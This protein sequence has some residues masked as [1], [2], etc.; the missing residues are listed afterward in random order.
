METPL[1]QNLRPLCALILCLFF[2]LAG[3]SK[4]IEAPSQLFTGNNYK[5]GQQAFVNVQ[6]FSAD[7]KVGFSDGQRG[8]NANMRW[9]QDGQEYQF[10]LYGPL[11]SGAVQIMGG[12]NHVSLTR[13]DGHIIKSKSPEALVHSELGWVIPVSGL[14]Y[15]LRGIPAPGTAPVVR[16]DAEKRIW[17]IIQQGWTISYQSYREVDGRMLPFK[18]TLV[19]GPIR[20]KF[21]FNSWQLS[22]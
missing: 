11:G 16:L 2:I 12:T 20:L 3:C 8:G 13:S 5:V 10:R 7:G 15:W 19:N 1:K 18:L 4:T 14:S 21:I 17:Q 22:P 6:H 9:V